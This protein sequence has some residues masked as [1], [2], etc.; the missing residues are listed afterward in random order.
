MRKPD[1]ARDTGQPSSWI[2]NRKFSKRTYGIGEFFVDIS[3]LTKNVRN[4]RRVMREKRIPSAF[5]E[6]LM[7]SVTSVYGCR[8]CCWLHTREALRSGVEQ[9]E[10]A[11]LLTGSMDNCPE[12]EA[13][14]LLYAQHWADS[15]ARP[16]PEA[17]GRLDEA[18]GAEKA[19]AINLIL[20]MIRVGNLS[21]NTW[22]RLLSRISR[23]RWGK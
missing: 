7:L 10:I 17:V 1:V 21:G 12:D 18:Y 14:A 22:D 8:Y 23:G 3:F 16:D 19:E 20:R 13:I 11:G 9:E 4:V 5:R 15:D 2:A 6:R